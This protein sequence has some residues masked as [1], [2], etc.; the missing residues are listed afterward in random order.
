[1][2]G[3]DRILSVDATGVFALN[4]IYSKIAGLPAAILWLNAI[5]GSPPEFAYSVLAHAPHGSD[6]STQ[7][8]L[9]DDGYFYETS[10]GYRHSFI[11]VSDLENR[12]IAQ[13]RMPETVFAEGLTKIGDDLYVLSWRAGQLSVF[14]A[15]S[16]QLRKLFHFR[17]EG[18]GL[19]HTQSGFVMSDGSDKL[20]FRDLK[21]FAI[22][23]II[24][25]HDADQYYDQLNELEYAQGFIWA[26]IWKSSRILKISPH[27]GEVA[28]I[29]DLRDLVHDHNADPVRAAL[30]GIAF[31]QQQNAFWVTGK[32]W[33]KRYLIRI[34]S[35][36]AA[37]E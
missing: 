29:I 2:P 32:N 35:A 16:L 14:D 5:A 19:T 11:R 12:L 6:V 10:G 24:R 4:H 34:E 37:H 20:Y 22:K 15:G 25:V 27:S 8:F 36:T 30:N 31:D 26:N 13:A 17:G 18:W 3:T 9:F 23:K 7:G 21:T 33:S 1:M 28:G